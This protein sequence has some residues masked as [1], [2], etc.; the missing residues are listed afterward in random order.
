[1]TPRALAGRFGLSWDTAGR[2]PADAGL[3]Q[4]EPGIEVE[5][6]HKL[7]GDERLATRQ[8]AAELEVSKTRVLHTL[9]AAG[10]AAKLRTVRQPRGARPPSPTL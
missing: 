2:S 10:I 5:R 3:L 4:A 9:A 7:Y 8:V 1:M 6:R